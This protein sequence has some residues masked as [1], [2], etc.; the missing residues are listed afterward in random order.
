VLLLSDSERPALESLMMVRRVIPFALP[1]RRLR[2]DMPDSQLNFKAASLF[3]MTFSPEDAME[4]FAWECKPAARY[5]ACIAF[6]AYFPS[7]ASRN[8][9]IRRKEKYHNQGREHK[10][11]MTIPEICGQLPQR[12]SSRSAVANC[13]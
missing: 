4:G 11:R 7:R 1:L 6:A 12:K 5:S 13:P 3:G 2:P 10:S 8:S 9:R